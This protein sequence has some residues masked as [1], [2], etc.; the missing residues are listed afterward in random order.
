[1]KGHLFLAAYALF[2]FGPTVPPAVG[3]QPSPRDLESSDQPITVIGEREKSEE[4]RRR[5]AARFVDS[6]AV[7][8]RIGQFARWHEPICVRTWGLPLEFNAHISSRVM[9]I[10][11]SLGIPT[12]RAELCRP[13]VRIGFTSEPQ[14]LVERAARRNRLVIGFHY[15][16]QRDQVMRVRQPVQAWYMTTTRPSSNS[17]SVDQG[18]SS[19]EAI[20]EAG[21]R[22]PG[23]GAGS[24]LTNY[25]SS[26]LGHV[27]IFADTRHVEGEDAGS[28]ADLLAFLALAQT[29]VAEACDESPTIINLMNPACPPSRRPAALTAHD[30]AYLRAL[31]R[32]DPEA[33]PQMQRGSLV[34]DMADT[35]AD[36]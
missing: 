10:A 33:G 24:R 18:G 7:R 2:G 11:E 23:G 30:I 9:D 27:M 4:Q 31:Y 34:L 25:I 20:D 17:G 28:I 32:M 29:P 21:V 5:E 1:M 8:T 13:N 35:L 12:N 22:A 36:R 15:A 3:Q 14:T 6:H 26:G 19:G 16:A